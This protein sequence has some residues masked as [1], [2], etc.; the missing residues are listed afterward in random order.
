MLLLVASTSFSQ[1][2]RYLR[3]SSSSAVIP[4]RSDVSRSIWTILYSNQV[5]SVDSVRRGAFYPS[6]R[7]I[8]SYALVLFPLYPVR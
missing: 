6:P 3:L 2:T 1:I 4:F 7:I 8:I 5:V